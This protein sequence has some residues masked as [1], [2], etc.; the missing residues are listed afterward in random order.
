MSH[1]AK[2]S[3]SERKRL[4]EKKLTKHYV[5]NILTHWFNVA[6]WA[7]LM[8]TGL[9]ILA[10]KTMPFMPVAWSALMRNLFGGLAP[11]I[12]A[13]A[14]WGQIWLA[15]LGFNVLIGF[16]KYFMPFAATRMWIDKDDVLWLWRKPRE[17]LFQDVELP[18]QDAYN[19]GQK[20]YSY[21]VVAGTLT[22][23]VTGLIMTYSEHI[24][25]LWMVQWSQPLHFL[26]MGVTFAGV[27]LH[28]YMGAIMPEERQAFFSMFNGKVSALYAYLH[29]HKWY[30][31]K[32]AEEAE[33]EAE[34]MA[35]H[36]GDAA[37]AADP[38]LDELTAPSGAAG[39]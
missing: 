31:Q 36:L 29:H 6:S 15:V 13:H 17:M 7:L 19:G 38:L 21:L 32:M 24:P 12:Q 16:R 14:L 25:Y 20:L 27:I 35:Q 5:A 3:L 1:N 26:A 34:Y 28:V 2:L 39:D 4:K 23:G 30:E 22:I 37:H 11:L 8:P 33:A 9:G 18:P 10:N